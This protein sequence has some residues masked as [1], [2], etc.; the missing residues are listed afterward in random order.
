MRHR[1]LQLVPWIV[2][3]DVGVEDSRFQLE[4]IGFRPHSLRVCVH[5]RDLQIEDANA[6]AAASS[7]ALSP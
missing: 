4:H 1:R 2:K 6:G 5:Q 3:V 7:S